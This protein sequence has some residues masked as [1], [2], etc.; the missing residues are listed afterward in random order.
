V[1]G[2]QRFSII[3]IAATLAAGC[4]STPSTPGPSA[5]PSASTELSPSPA[6][7]SA[8]GSPTEL[9]PTPEASPDASCPAPDRNAPLPSPHFTV[10]TPVG[11]YFL[12]LAV[13]RVSSIDDS[14]QFVDVEVREPVYLDD[15][16]RLV[17]G[18]TVGLDP[19]D[20]M[21][22]SITL[23]AARAT[24]RTGGGERVAMEGAVGTVP[25]TGRPGF[26]F[27]VP[28]VTATSG[29]FTAE[30]S[31]G[32]FVYRAERVW[33]LRMVLAAE[34]AGCP[35]GHKGYVRHWSDMGEPPVFVGDVGV[36]LARIETVGFWVPYAVSS[37]GNTG[38]TSWSPSN[39]SAS[40]S[41]GSVIAVVPA[42]DDLT[43]VS[44]FAQFYRRTA[45]ERWLAGGEM[46]DD[47]FSSAADPYPDRRFDLLVPRKPGRYVASLHYVSETPCAHVGAVGAVSIDV[48]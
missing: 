47:V 37:Q 11:G 18:S 16:V 8:P 44:L 35:G 32:C 38:L 34:A 5:L 15:P 33:G 13:T 26:L 42:S 7:T 2:L 10:W 24:L 25:K 19:D 12:S 43:P 21:G 23:V 28:D 22:S 36:E 14:S 41:P 17:G 27:D 40:A 48:E 39:S 45:V 30:W 31:D 9:D 29:K 46:P 20:D 6:P 4:G 1:T 3:A